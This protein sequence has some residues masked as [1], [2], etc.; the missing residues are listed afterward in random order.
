M[1]KTLKS[2]GCK[3]MKTTKGKM[4]VERRNIV[5]D[6]IKFTHP[7]NLRTGGPCIPFIRNTG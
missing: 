4:M 2:G 7:Y 5:V 3:N 6:E 1:N